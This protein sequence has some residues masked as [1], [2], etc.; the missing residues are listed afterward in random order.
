[1]PHFPPQME[2]E[3]EHRAYNSSAVWHMIGG[4]AW[5]ESLAVKPNRSC[6]R[7]VLEILS[8]WV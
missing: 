1:M 6:G 8:D 2:N 7:I 5:L 3:V 4:Y